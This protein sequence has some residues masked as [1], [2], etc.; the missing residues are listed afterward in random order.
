[1]YSRLPCWPT[2]ASSWNQ[3]SIGLP[4]TE[5]GKASLSRVAK[6]FKCHLGVRILLWMVGPRLQPAQPKLVQPFANGAFVHS[7]VEA[8]RDLL[9]QVQASPAGHLVNG[10][11]G[12]IHDQP[13]QLR[14]LI[15]RQRRRGARAVQRL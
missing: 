6:F 12:A 9:A 2:L 13:P 11:I 1:M 4:A 8:A 14:H 10:G 5:A 15:G 7:H 3:T